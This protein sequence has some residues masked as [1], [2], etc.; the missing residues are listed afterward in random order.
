MNNLKTW[1]RFWLK[2]SFMRRVGA[3]PQF[4]AD[5]EINNGNNNNKSD[6]NESDI[7]NMSSN[8]KM[9]HF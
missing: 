9:W 8:N 6:N 2:I 5:Y 1:L 7:N 4:A 3:F